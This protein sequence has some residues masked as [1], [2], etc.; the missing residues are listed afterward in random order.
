M[1]LDLKLVG[2]AGLVWGIIGLALMLL[3]AVLGR[4]VP[5][6]FGLEGLSLV[7]Y[8][9]LFA[10]VHFGLRAA[11]NW[12]IALVGGALAGTLAALIIM[13]VSQFVPFIG[14]GGFTVQGLVGGFIA[15]LCGGLGIKL[16]QRF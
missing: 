2:K 5:A 10:G 1:V 15:G 11:G 7:G 3:I 12:I 9:A 8:A 16:A 6:S 4:F 13:L 14:G